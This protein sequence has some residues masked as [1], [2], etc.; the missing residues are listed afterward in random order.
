MKLESALIR[1]SLFLALLTAMSPAKANTISFECCSPTIDLP[2]VASFAFGSTGSISDV[3]MSV[4]TS[5][6]S[7]TP[8]LTALLALTERGAH[9][10]GATLTVQAPG[11]IET[12]T[13]GNIVFTSFTTGALNT[14][15]TFAYTSFATEITPV[16]I[17][18]AVWLLLSGLGGLGLFARKR[19]A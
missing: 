12:D 9:E 19:A 6:P 5:N 14:S 10:S 1:T 4:P 15:V 8:G 17:P 2:D 7:D 11:G 13:F 16:P 3:T 18:A